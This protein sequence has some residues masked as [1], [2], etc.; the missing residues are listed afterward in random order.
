MS[1]DAKKLKQSKPALKARKGHEKATPDTHAKWAEFIEKVR[2]ELG[3]TLEETCDFTD[4][5]IGWLKK[6]RDGQ[7]VRGDFR[8]KFED[9]IKKKWQ[10]NFPDKP[11]L[12]WPAWVDGAP[13]S[14]PS[15]PAS[16]PSLSAAISKPSTPP[17]ETI[18]VNIQEELGRG[19]KL[20][21]EGKYSEAQA[22]YE[23]ALQKA[24]AAGHARARFKARI[25]LA[26]AIARQESDRPRAKE[27]LNTCLTELK[28]E[29]DSDRR[30]RV[31]YLLG[32][33]AMGEGKIIEAKSLY[34]EALQG[35]RSRSDRFDEGS[36]LVGVAQAEEMLGNLGEAHRLLDEAAD[37]YRAEHRK[38]SSDSKAKAATNLGGCYGEKATVH[39]H[40]GKWIESLACLT[41]AEKWFRESRS[42]DNLARMLFLKAEA[43]LGDS[44][45]KPG[46]TALAE[47]F[48]IFDKL[49]NTR[50]MLR[51]YD[52]R[53]RAAFQTDHWEEAIG[54]AVAAI[55]LA[56]KA[57]SPSEQVEALGQAA[58]LCR[59]YDIPEKAS[60][61]LAEAKRLAIEHELTDALVRCLQSEASALRGEESETQRAALL[62]EAISHLEALLLR[63]EIKGRR[64]YY[65]AEIG[66]LF[67]RLGNLVEARS[68]IEQ[69]LKNYE[70]IGDVGG[71]A[72]CLGSLAATAREEKNPAQAIELLEKLLE[73]SK[74]KAFHHFQAGAHHDLV[75]LK[76]SQGDIAAARRHLDTCEAITKQHGFRDISEHLLT[77]R[78]RL[79]HAERSRRPAG[80]DLAAMLRDLHVWKNRYPAVA[81]AILPFW[82][83]GFSADLWSNC[84]SLFGVKFLVRSSSSEG[85]ERFATDFSALGDL[86][87]YA[88]SFPLKAV[89]G[90]DVIPSYDKLLL[91]ACLHCVGFEGKAPEGEEG[92][93]ALIK[94][95]D[96]F[97][98][99]FTAF[100]GPVHGFP[101]AKAAILGRR[102]RVPDEVRELMFGVDAEN[103]I[104]RRIIAMPVRERED[105]SSLIHDM[106]IAWENGLLPVF[107]GSLPSPGEVNQEREVRLL[108]PIQD[109]VAKNSLRKFMSDLRA[110]PDA[111]LARLVEELESQAP[112]PDGSSSL[113][114]VR[115]TML[116]FKAGP[117]NVIHPALVIA[118]K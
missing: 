54:L 94:V 9:A 40:E 88:A 1:S 5:E 46:L 21:G 51:C 99:F 18:P 72:N 17:E 47:A 58:A 76:L 116:K 7:N 102:Y 66:E 98:Y 77:T 75:W 19:D 114:P 32:F 29:P 115:L 28:S 56:K 62:R 31:L 85:F 106:C 3:W 97:P 4:I 101:D 15:F 12:A 27:L 95:L 86:F 23:S 20:D 63:T 70:E 41:E 48:S 45:W 117:S 57:A 60:E 118:E 11:P 113:M 110:N 69:A 89:H 79:E 112:G 80:R 107:F 53:A 43:L 84:R 100:S 64:A 36:Y 37:L 2:K 104:A 90:I 71:V 78:Q 13:W 14:E 87:V 6:A 10:E 67:G 35:A 109:S 50:S 49:G 8:A 55:Q 25:D 59:K 30:D 44:Q 65:M 108:L 92:A 96:K 105:D 39:R 33:I 82:Y 38:L 68:W 111:A 81:D 74:G 16:P 93:K 42:E 73:R 22:I 103:L 83:W 26:E 24:E 52:L 91:P 61:Y 34:R